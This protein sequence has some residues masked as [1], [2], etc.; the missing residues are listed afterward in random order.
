VY[1]RVRVR[2]GGVVLID[3]ECDHIYI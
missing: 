2:G 1:V 3:C